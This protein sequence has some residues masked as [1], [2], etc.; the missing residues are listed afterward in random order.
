MGS[1]NC[2]LA[3]TYNW[4]LE[5]LC[6]S[7]TS[8]FRIF[9]RIDERIRGT[10][11]FHTE[12]PLQSDFIAFTSCQKTTTLTSDNNGVGSLIFSLAHFFNNFRQFI[13]VGSH[14]HSLARSY[15]RTSGRDYRS[16]NSGSGTPQR[17]D[18][19][20]RIPLAFHTESVQTDF[21]ITPT[22]QRT[23]AQNLDNSGVGSLYFSLATKN[24]FF[25]C[26]GWAPLQY[27][28]WPFIINFFFGKLN[29]RVHQT[30]FLTPH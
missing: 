30:S 19:R 29:H 5:R 7:H 6:W 26:E 21:I 22:C 10:L 3:Q 11:A 27:F 1:L 28:F 4:K 13:G 23:T 24:T 2:S 18:E 20:A 25:P 17:F 14:N 9:Q 15:S 8:G 16:Y 12:S